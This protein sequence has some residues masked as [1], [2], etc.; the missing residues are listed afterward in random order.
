MNNYK[1]LS[2]KDHCRI[3]RYNCSEMFSFSFNNVKLDLTKEELDIFREVISSFEPVWPYKNNENSKDLVIRSQLTSN[4]L[5]GFTIS[6]WFTLKELFDEAL[7]M[8]EFYGTVN[9][10]IN[11][12]ENAN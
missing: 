1:V 12:N 5:F 4:I 3:I 2:E 10:Y 6:E 11:Y 9:E 7:V 8:N